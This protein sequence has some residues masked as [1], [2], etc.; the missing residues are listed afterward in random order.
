[1]AFSKST[2]M[3]PFQI[4]SLRQRAHVAH[5]NPGL[6]PPELTS[7]LARMWRVLSPVEK[8]EYIDAALSC[9]RRDRTPRKRRRI[10][11][12]QQLVPTDTRPV[13]AHAPE[14]AIVPRG[15]SGLSVARASEQIV[16]LS[17]SGSHDS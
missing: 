13:D 14:F 3:E 15:V 12:S 8:Q 5:E 17:P 9:I 7:L 11:P 10:R 16:F 6:S 4:F 1:M 2:R